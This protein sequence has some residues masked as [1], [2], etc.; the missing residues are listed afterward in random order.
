MLLVSLAVLSSAAW[1]DPAGATKHFIGSRE[2]SSAIPFGLERG[3][4]EFLQVY[5]SRLFPKYGIDISQVAFST[6]TTF[7]GQ[8]RAWTS[9]EVGLSTTKQRAEGL[10]SALETNQG[11]DRRTIAAFRPYKLVA[12]GHGQYDIVFNVDPPFQ[13]SP[14][15][16]NL[17]LELRFGVPLGLVAG[18]IHVLAGKSGDMSSG[19]R[20]SNSP[21]ILRN[22]DGALHT[23]FMI[24]PTANGSE[25]QP[26]K[27]Q[28]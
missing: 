14:S 20:V 19:Y 22:I 4:F 16:G 1:V 23:R 5:E 8:P 2:K 24:R 12:Q 7:R 15:Q 11:P 6:T 17:L 26:K 27:A 10:T 18:P 13:Y 3:D 25:P 21:T 9:L 28:P